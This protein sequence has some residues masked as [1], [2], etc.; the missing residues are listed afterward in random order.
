MAVIF[1]V[2]LDWENRRRDRVQGVKIDPE[3][4][5]AVD[6]ESDEALADVDETD[7]QNKNFRYIL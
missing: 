6:L 7:V 3:E 1:R 4:T 5:R 2:Y